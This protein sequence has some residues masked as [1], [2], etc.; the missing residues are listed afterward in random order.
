MKCP[1]VHPSI[2]GRTDRTDVVPKKIE[3]GLAVNS[4]GIPTKKHKMATRVADFNNTGR[5][6]GFVI[7]S[8]ETYTMYMLQ[9]AAMEPSK[10]KNWKGTLTDTARFTRTKRSAPSRIR[11]LGMKRRRTRY[12]TALEASK[13]LV[14]DFWSEGPKRQPPIFPLCSCCAPRSTKEIH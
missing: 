11:R 12:R 1:S 2:K 7:T 9:I 4:I 3:R 8:D 14:S 10:R 6:R 5:K 13:R